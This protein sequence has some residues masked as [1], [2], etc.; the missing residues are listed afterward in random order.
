MFM[1]KYVTKHVI[2]S[3]KHFKQISAHLISSL[4]NK[5]NKLIWSKYYTQS[6]SLNNQAY[7]LRHAIKD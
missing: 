1:Q 2:F 3:S 5:S 4:F 7:Q 6:P